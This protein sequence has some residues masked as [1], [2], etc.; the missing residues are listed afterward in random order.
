MK[1]TKLLVLLL[2]FVLI[3][4]CKQ[5]KIQIEEV[6]IIY[7]S[8]EYNGKKYDVSINPKLFLTNNSNKNMR[9]N[10]SD[11]DSLSIL[12]N[13][14]TYAMSVMD[15][16]LKNKKEL[17]PNEKLIVYYK[18]DYHRVSENFDNTIITDDI[19][20]SVIINKRKSVIGKSSKF[21]V[22]PR[23]KAYIKKIY[24]TPNGTKIEEIGD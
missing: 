7:N 22:K 10:V 14:T 20:K 11:I 12:I 1:A 23:I 3:S 16:S 13:N 18:T 5:M 4:S 8:E 2:A 19:L 17:S 9:F 15:D 6:E 21:V 24:Y